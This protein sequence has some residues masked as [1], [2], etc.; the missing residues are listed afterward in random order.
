MDELDVFPIITRSLQLFIWINVHTLTTAIQ[1]SEGTVGIIEVINIY[2]R[3][4]KIF[5]HLTVRFTQIR[6]QTE[7]V[8][9]FL[10]VGMMKF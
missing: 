3:I 10:D 7:F 8:Y 6:C 4:S 5:R 9:M 1:K 2:F